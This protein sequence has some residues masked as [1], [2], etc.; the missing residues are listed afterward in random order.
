MNISPIN[1]TSFGMA[2]FTEEGMRL[3]HEAGAKNETQFNNG[4]FY[5]DKYWFEPPFSKYLKKTI[6]DNAKKKVDA[7]TIDEVKN[8][9]VEHGTG[10]NAQ[11]NAIFIKQLM[12]PKT[13]KHIKNLETSQPDAQKEIIS[14]EKTVFDANWNNPE[15]SK[16]K[17]KELLNIVKSKMSDAEYVKWSGIIDNS[18]A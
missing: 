8:S 12:H 17:T 4:K 9:I 18:D 10:V 16:G 13:Q 7:S 1:A 11:T 14:A 3:A 5:N 15:I 6:P 2:R